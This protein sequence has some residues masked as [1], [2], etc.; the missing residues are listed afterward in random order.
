MVRLASGIQNDM[1]EVKSLI[2]AL[3]RHKVPRWSFHGHTKEVGYH[4]V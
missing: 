2:L 1:K 3:M 4:E